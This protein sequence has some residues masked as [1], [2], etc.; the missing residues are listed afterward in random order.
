ME[1]SVNYIIR[2]VAKGDEPF[3]WK[4][5][6]YAAHMGEEGETSLQAARDNPDLMKYVKDWGRKSD[7]GF[8]ALEAQS[9]QPLGVAW[10]RLLIGKDKTIS[11]IDE[12][13]PELAIAVLP[14]AIGKGIG[15][16][17][18]TRVLEAVK[19]VYP[20]VVLSVRATNPA[21][22]L[23]ERMGFVVVSNATNRVGTASVNML[24]K[25][26]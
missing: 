13:T 21:I 14:S 11:Y 7:I 22:H 8:I 19:E 15:T 5:L 1:K 25:F 12:H 16:Q 10:V 4:M 6:Y 20:A 24:I 3:L 26:K 23:Y 18:L 17:L 9:Q 2:S